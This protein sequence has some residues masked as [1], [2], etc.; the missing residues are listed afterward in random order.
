MKLHRGSDL[1][2]VI[3]LILFLSSTIGSATFA[4][5]SYDIGSPTLTDIWVDPVSGDDNNSGA[6]V[7]QPLKTITAA[8][9]LIPGEFTNTG[10]RINL[11]PGTY[12]CE[13]GPEDTNCINYFADRAGTYQFPLILS[14]YNGP[15][16]ATIRGGFNLA[17]VHYLYL[18]DL[19]LVGGMSLPT[20]SS[21][22][23]LLH[24]ANSDYVLLR[25]MS[26]TGPECDNDSCNNLQEVLKV[27]QTQH[28]YVENSTI[29]GAWHS[30]VDYM[31]VQYGHFLN[32][33]VHTA[34]QW[35]MYVK[36]GSS[37]L[38]IEGNEFGDRTQR[39]QLGFQAGQ[40]ANF[41]MMQSPWLHYEAYAIKFVNNILHDIPGVGM[42]VS[43]GYNILFAY[44]TLYRVATSTDPA[45]GLIHFVFGERG[46]SPTDEMPGAVSQ[47]R[48]FVNQG[49]W[50]PNVLQVESIPAIP[51]RNVY[52]YNNIFYNP[53][54]EKT[55]YVDFEIP[56]PISRPEG[57]QNSPDPAYTD[58]NLV[59]RG[60]LIWNGPVDH[61]LGIEESDQGCQPTNL[62]CNSIQLRADNTINTL[63]PQ[64][65]NPENGNFRPVEGGNV[66]GATT[67]TI[68][69]FLWNDAPTQPAVPEGNL[70]NQIALDRDK[71]QRTPPGPPGA[72]TSGA[73]PPTMFTL[74]V[75]KGGSG[76]GS[77]VSTPAGINCGSDCTEA[78]NP[79]TVVTLTA[80][81]VSGSTFEGWS[82]ACSGTGQCSVT[83]DAN[84]TV[85]ATFNQQQ[86]TLMVTKAGTGG[87]TV[88]SSPA[89]INCGS[90]CSEAYNEGA[91][92]I[93]TA[94]AS[95]S[96]TF[97]GWSGVCSGT[98]QC[99]VTMDTD[100]AVTAT[101]N[102]QQFTLMVTKAGTGSG[103]VTS[104]PTG[105]NCGSDCSET[106]TKVQKVKLTAKANT[107]S[108]FTGWEGGSCSG[109]KTC[110]VTVDATITVTADFALKIPDISVVQTTLDFGNVKLGKKAT[111]TLKIMNIGTGDLVIGLSVLEGTD[112]SI[113]G[114]SSVTIKVR[115]SYSLKV[116]FTPKSA[117]LETANLR[118]SSN[119]PDTPT[120]DIPLTGTGL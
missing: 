61:P 47:C 78:Y 116:L 110:T 42:S 7:G 38:R 85:T 87:G 25:G 69:D 73:T 104:N 39:C 45:Y 10:Y 33:R 83:M 89:G 20:N 96:S 102:Q 71:N 65:I 82:G 70:S 32:N 62:T 107:D 57:F 13:P 80:T 23:N 50:G 26:I 105:I 6:S 9:N 90:D 17:N 79:G 40:S 117:G 55:P 29:G 34:G 24:L 64:L 113:Q 115:K 100:K 21:G 91:N 5:S 66:F 11:L 84:K 14:A 53:S 76:I 74:T 44:N 98:G 101:F 4:Q 77:V 48:D 46:C 36:G 18:I 75:Q 86:Y 94:T 30:S 12:P 22:N 41:A 2:F 68:P 15:N 111:K 28:L 51:N 93:L 43:G 37:Y 72:Y 16:T 67:Y 19:N 54:P 3:L 114:S 109:T 31:V 103:T 112:F 60:N 120:V 95:A 63:E 59:I 27:N 119:D 106:Y 56:G 97:T 81:P 35:C 99:S 118:V 1:K 58:N 92:V 49:G 52:V 8:W 88:T 108:T